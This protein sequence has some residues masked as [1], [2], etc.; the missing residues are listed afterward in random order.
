M[1]VSAGELAQKALS[2]KSD[3]NL[4]ELGHAL[5]EDIP[6]ELRNCIEI[7][8]PM[9][10]EREFCVI[11]QKATD[12][13][14]SPLLRYKYFAWPYLPSPRPDQVVFLYDKE[15]DDI[16]KRLWTLPSA[17]RMAQLATTTSSVPKEYERMQAWSIAFF[18]GRF[19]EYI[20]YEHGIMMPSEHE[21]FLEHR[22]KLIQAG[23]KVPDSSYSE[24]FDFDKIYIEKVINTQEAMIA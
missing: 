14:I 4:L 8:K 24:P 16:T 18:Q 1:R 2:D 17:A 12:C 11:R 7:Y 3:Y 22:E 9:I 23:C 15:K 13:L 6:K 21:Y 10:G 20:R 5:C 19:W